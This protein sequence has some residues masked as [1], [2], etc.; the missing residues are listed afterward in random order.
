MKNIKSSAI[1][2]TLL[3]MTVT[4]SNA[5]KNANVKGSWKM[6]V[7]TSAG[8]GTPS[9]ELTHLT[10]TTL[11]G[12]YEGR[13]GEAKVTGTVK[14]NIVH[15]EFSISDTQIE[16]D[17]TVDGDSMKGKVKLGSMGDGTFT[18]TRKKQ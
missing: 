8:S 9:F 16:Y 11:T 5:Q 17:G 18:G 7:E 10:E 6:E 3:M 14:G 13:L 12:T 2:V 15:L 4:T 1:L